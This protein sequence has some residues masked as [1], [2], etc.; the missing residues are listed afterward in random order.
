MSVNAIVARRNITR[1]LHFT[2]NQGLT[3]ILASRAVK[4]RRDLTS[5]K[6]LEHVYS[7]NCAVRRDQAWLGYVNLS[8]G[9]INARLWDI[10]ANKWHSNKDSWWCILVFDPIVLTHPGV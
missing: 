6:Y 10:S 2:T 9:R 4:A 1:V 8:I 3:G 7:P 5:D